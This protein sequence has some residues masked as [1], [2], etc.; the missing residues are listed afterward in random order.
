MTAF[1]VLTEV[2]HGCLSRRTVWLVLGAHDIKRLLVDSRKEIL[3]LLSLKRAKVPEVWI[4]GEQPDFGI[5][6]FLRQT[7]RPSDNCL[8]LLGLKYCCQLNL[9]LLGL[10]WRS[11]R[12][13]NHGENWQVGHQGWI[14]GYQ[15]LHCGWLTQR[16][17]VYQE[18][19]RSYHPPWSDDMWA[20]L[21]DP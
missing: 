1:G 14:Q 9:H 10:E 17:K 2:G 7:K 21:K 11:G 18:K 8:A 15:E 12:S 5:L 3:M 20:S 4:D 6:Q 19:S 16:T 13:A